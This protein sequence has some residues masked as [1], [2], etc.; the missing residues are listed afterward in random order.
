MGGDDGSLCVARSGYKG[1]NMN[2]ISYELFERI[3]NAFA[4][5]MVSE[6]H[7]F[8]NGLYQERSE[9]ET[10]PPIWRGGDITNMYKWS[11]QRSLLKLVE[12]EPP[13]ETTPEN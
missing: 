10:A 8:S 2:K 3:S 1:N 11:M 6:L 7:K 13:P 12:V 5:K 9:D 4:E